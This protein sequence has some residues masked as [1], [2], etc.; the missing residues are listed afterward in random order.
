M[1]HFPRRMSLPALILI[2]AACA[3]GDAARQRRDTVRVTAVT[4]CRAGDDTVFALAL[5]KYVTTIQPTPRRFLASFGSDSALPERAMSVLQNRGPTWLFPDDTARQRPVRE[6]LESAGAYATLLVY[7]YGT[8][9]VDPS[10]STIRL[11]GRYIG[12]ELDGNLAS[13]RVVHV[14]CTDGKWSADSV[15]EERAS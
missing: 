14:R 6:R 12:G 15:E 3:G 4:V 5:D 10:H 13:R 9:K 7:Q 1:R 8:T 11:G 2:A